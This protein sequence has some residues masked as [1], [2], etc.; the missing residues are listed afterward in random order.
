MDKIKKLTA[1]T[2]YQRFGGVIYGGDCYAYALL[3]TGFV[4]IIFEPELKVYDFAALIPIIK[5]AGGFIGD[6]HGNEIELKSNTKLL[7]CSTKELYDEV[8]K[9]IT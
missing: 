8:I 4:D 9:L 6:W 2:K 5:Q 7:A 1:K 3:A